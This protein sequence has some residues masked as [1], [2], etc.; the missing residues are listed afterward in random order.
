MIVGVFSYDGPSVQGP[1]EYLEQ[2][3]LALLDDLL[4]VPNRELDDDTIE[5]EV[6]AVLMEEYERW[7]ARAAKAG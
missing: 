7:L 4:A 3:G 6:L 1:A 2:E 5:R